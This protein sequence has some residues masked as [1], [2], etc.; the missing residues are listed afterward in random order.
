MKKPISKIVSGFGCVTGLSRSRWRNWLRNMKE[1]MMWLCM[2]STWSDRICREGPSRC[3]EAMAQ[4]TGLPIH[5]MRSFAWAF[6]SSFLQFLTFHYLCLNME[7]PQARALQSARVGG[8][9]PL[10]PHVQWCCRMM[11]ITMW[12]R[13][14][15]IEG[16]ERVS[17]LC[18]AFVAGVQLAVH[19]LRWKLR[20]ITCSSVEGGKSGRLDVVLKPPTNGTAFLACPLGRPNCSL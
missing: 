19:T 4:L 6:V 5:S 7:G 14:L 15:Q 11:G 17:S 16:E 10:L 2:L 8:S 13:C 3:S 12:Y 1:I 18:G 20:A 9:R